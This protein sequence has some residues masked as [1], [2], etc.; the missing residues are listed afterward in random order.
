MISI[1]LSLLKDGFFAAL[2]A[3]GF[4]A[5]SNPS[6]RVLPW[7]CLAAACGHM[8]RFLLMTYAGWHLTIAS[9]IASCVIGLIS[10]PMAGHI[11]TPAEF[12][13]FP[14]LLPMVPG[15]YAYRAVQAIVYCIQI[16]DE[17]AFMHYMYLL[18]YNGIIFIVTILG[19][20]VG[21]TLPIFAFTKYSFSVTKQTRRWNSDK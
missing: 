17:C 6:P 3:M 10:L 8:T 16:P 20:V 15:M 5:I 2:A 19:M 7:C 14:A 12:I 4:A 13:S 21:A 9:F 11:K 18:T 1:L